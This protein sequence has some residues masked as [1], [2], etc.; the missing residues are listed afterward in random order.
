MHVCDYSN[1][2]YSTFWINMPKKSIK[3]TP[4]MLGKNLVTE[5]NIKSLWKL[6]TTGIVRHKHRSMG[7]HW[8]QLSFGSSIT[9]MLFL[10]ILGFTCCFSRFATYRSEKTPPKPETPYF[11]KR[12]M[13]NWLSFRVTCKKKKRKKRKIFLKVLDLKI[14]VC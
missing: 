11:A 5:S 8:H 7:C 2:K 13:L 3:N 4:R 9:K 12:T 14:I 1:V 6:N 10:F